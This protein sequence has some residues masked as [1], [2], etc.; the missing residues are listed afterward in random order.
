MKVKKLIV[1]YTFDFELY[2]L[3]TSLKDYKLAWLINQQLNIKLIRSD[4][5]S[6]ESG[7]D[8]IEIINYRF[9]E[10]LSE[11]RLFKNKA[12]LEGQNA[13]QYLVSEMKHFDYFILVKGIIHTFA[14]Y[15]LLQELRA[16]EGLQLINQIDIE[17]LKSKEH[18]IF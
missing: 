14:A 17:K 12:V 16:I 15:D 10:E 3:T 18:F 9:E 6:L 1:D 11:L 5:Y 8:L 2:G 13:Q 7:S 4:D